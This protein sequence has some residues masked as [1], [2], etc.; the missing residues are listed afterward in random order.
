MVLAGSPVSRE[1]AHQGL[2]RA[3]EASK[4]GAQGESV[5]QQCTQ[6]GGVAEVLHEAEQV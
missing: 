3:W 6:H 1:G 5:S 4:E 2:L